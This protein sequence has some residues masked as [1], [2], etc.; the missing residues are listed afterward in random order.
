MTALTE[1]PAPVETYDERV[2]RSMR[3][4]SVIRVTDDRWLG[5]G[6]IHTHPFQET[7]SG[8]NATVG[9]FFEYGGWG[10]TE[11]SIDLGGASSD[12]LYGDKPGVY[13]SASDG[14]NILV[15]GTT[16][17]DDLGDV[18]A[19]RLAAA[20]QRRTHADHYRRACRRFSPVTQSARASYPRPQ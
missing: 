4:H 9:K 20:P 12:T 8:T 19:Q 18:E 13:A 7:E 10:L 2:A 11:S 14:G 1:T 5:D 17:Y 16:S 3:E 15:G 6:L